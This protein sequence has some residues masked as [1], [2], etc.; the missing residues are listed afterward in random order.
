PEAAATVYWTR[1]QQ[2][3]AAEKK[4]LDKNLRKVPG[5]VSDRFMLRVN[6]LKAKNK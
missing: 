2:G 4:R 3:D 1:W 5:L 6:Q